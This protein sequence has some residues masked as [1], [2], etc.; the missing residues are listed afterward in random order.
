MRFALYS[1]YVALILCLLGVSCITLAVMLFA[2]RQDGASDDSDGAERSG[3]ESDASPLSFSLLVP[4]RHEEQVLAMTLDRLAEIEHDRF[5]VLVIVGDD[6]P[7]TAAVANAAVARHPSCIRVVVDEHLVKSK[8]RALNTALPCCHGDVIG[9]FDA[10]D[11]VDPAILQLVERRM[12]ADRCA[13]L[14]SGVQLMNFW[15]RWYAVRNVL[16]YYF[17]YRSKLYFQASKG[18]IPLGGNTVFV[19]R[20]V[21]E[22]IGG[23]D[24]DCLAE[25][26]DL[27]V[28]LSSRGYPISVV[29]DPLL[30]TRE[31]CP[32]TIE[33]FVRQRTRWDQG[34]LQVLF[35]GE[36]RR[37]HGPQRTFAIYTL[38]TPLIQAVSG[39][40]LPF[41]I[42]TIPLLSVPAG[43]AMLSFAPLLVL[44]ATVVVEHLALTEFGSIF[45][46]R[47]R[48]RH[49]V[50]LVVTT[51]PY[52]AV[53]AF[54]ALRAIGRQLRG[55]VGWE[56]TA[57]FGLHLS[58]TPS[59]EAA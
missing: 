33:A 22:A 31:E 49:H 7:G 6:D 21:L 44:L 23:W 11:E 28:R 52:H 35:K 54:A 27:G 39:L 8:P 34:Y 3:T 48:L 46:V 57:H 19:Y 29:Y 59:S 56:K 2:W 15:S 16:E 4:A 9:I 45:G 58:P 38:C 1:L 47:P 24:G 32:A 40:L 42:L 17:W 10:E 53:L 50:W 20:T 37:L 26:C 25:D 12:R 30:V 41:A 55:H 36:W 51:F 43:L 18:F 13:A 14:Q 5:E